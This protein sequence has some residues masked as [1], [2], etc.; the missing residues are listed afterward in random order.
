MNKKRK[1][2]IQSYFLMTMF[3]LS[4]LF[5]VSI[6]FTEQ[7]SATA[8]D[9]FLYHKKITI[10]GTTYVDNELADFPV[11]VFNTS[12]DFNSSSL[13]ADFHDIWVTLSDNTTSLSYERDEHS[14]DRTAGTIG[15][16]VKVPTIRSDVDTEIWI[17]YGDSDISG[18]LE[19]PQNVWNS[20][21]LLVSHLHDNTSTSVNDSTSNF[22]H[23]TKGGYTGCVEYSSGVMGYCQDTTSELINWTNLAKP[24]TDDYTYELWVNP[25]SQGG[26]YQVFSA[27]EDSQNKFYGYVTQGTEAYCVGEEANSVEIVTD[28]NHADFTPNGEWTH[29]VFAGDRDTSGYIYRNG[30]AMSLDTNTMTANDVSPSV[31]IRTGGYWD[32]GSVGLDLDGKYDEFRVSNVCRN[33]SWINAT[34]I[35]CSDVENFIT[36]GDA[37]NVE[38]ETTYTI[39]GLTNDRLTF[40]AITGN[41]AW[42]NSSGDAYETMIYTIIVNS[43][44]EVNNF[45]IQ[46]KDC[47]TTGDTAFINASNFSL[48]VSSNNSDFGLVGTATDGGLVNLTVN[49]SMWNNATMGTN[50][51]TNEKITDTTEILYFRVKLAGKSYTT[52]TYYPS[53]KMKIMAGNLS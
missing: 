27:Y 10:H 44:T 25:D 19:D 32:G 50:P 53:A 47:N 1:K 7:A 26:Q 28:K 5:V 24:G 38:G 31:P 12:S 36:L 45:R 17:H 42:C 9:Q 35:S 3:V 2:H 11:W 52:G 34:Y 48:Y 41:E 43:T 13:R 33:T 14:M 6:R 40:S 21:Y 22:N 20:G 39:T 18:D 16:Y 23:G 30:G 46:L 15:L 37:L 49:D 29:V 4:L 51:F 8:Y